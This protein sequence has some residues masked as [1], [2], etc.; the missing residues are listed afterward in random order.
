MIKVISTFTTKA[1]HIILYLLI[2]AFFLTF[3]YS[4]YDIL[5]G[6]DS[7]SQLIKL[8]TNSLKK[9]YHLNSLSHYLYKLL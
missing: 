2:M 7:W 8:I 5:I 1:I 6:A 3:I 4:F 9:L